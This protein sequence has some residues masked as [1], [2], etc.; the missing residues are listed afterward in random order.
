M[1]VFVAL[2]GKSGKLYCYSVKKEKTEYC[3]SIPISLIAS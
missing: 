3:N 2:S 1:R